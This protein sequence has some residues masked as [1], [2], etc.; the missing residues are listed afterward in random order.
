MIIPGYDEVVDKFALQKKLLLREVLAT[1]KSSGKSEFEVINAMAINQLKNPPANPYDDLARLRKILPQD[2]EQ[3]AKD[4]S[5]NLYEAL[6]KAGVSKDQLKVS[7]KIQKIKAKME[8][9][10][11]LGIAIEVKK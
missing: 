2:L 1:V 8:L 11:G 9:Y 10:I 5:N 4:R 7:D 6:I 3:L